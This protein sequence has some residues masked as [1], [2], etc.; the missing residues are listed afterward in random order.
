MARETV[1]SQHVASKAGVSQSAVSRVFSPGASASPEM[2]AKVKKVA[3]EL[4]YRPNVLARSLITGKSK[5]IGL[6]VAYLENQFYPDAVEKLSL[7]LQEEGYHVL[8]FM[9]KMTND[10]VDQILEE[11]LDYQVEGIVMASAFMSENLT[12]RCRRA[13][14]PV[15]F[16]NRRQADRA[17]SAI[18]SDNINGG[19]KVADFLINGG[20]Q[21]IAHIAGW[22]GASTQRDREKGFCGELEKQNVPLFDREVGNYHYESTQQAAR[23]MFGK[24]TIPDA[25]FVGNDHMALAVMECLRHDFGLR[26]PEDVSI[27]GYDDV[28][29]ASWPSF[30]LTTIRQPSNRMV[31]ETV[32]TLLNQ[33]KNSTAVSRQVEIDGPLVIR[34]SAR[35]PRGWKDEKL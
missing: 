7:A 12:E 10:N 9:T 16:F 11:L 13:G 21:R 5:M 2:T 35:I 22:E 27:V 18:T 34:R 3:A 4:G 30:A 15:V 23:I 24:K 28:E 29:L 14:V 32:I 17:L 8:M 25:V 1:T 31:S 33:I 6:V 26:V 19:R 20:H